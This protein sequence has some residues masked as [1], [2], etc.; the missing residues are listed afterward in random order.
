MYQDDIDLANEGREDNRTNNVLDLE[1]YND[2]FYTSIS[3]SN[4]SD[5]E[6]DYF[7]AQQLDNAKSIKVNYNSANNIQKLAQLFPEGVTE[8]GL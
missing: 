4:K 2:N 8:K 3:N 1:N 6:L 7:N 5:S